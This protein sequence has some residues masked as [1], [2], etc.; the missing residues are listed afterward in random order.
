MNEPTSYGLLSRTQ[1]FSAAKALPL[2]PSITYCCVAI[3]IQHFKVFNSWFGKDRADSVLFRIAAA[4]KE[5]VDPQDAETASES[6]CGYF[7]NDSF[8]VFMPY[9]ETM[10]QNIFIS[11][12]EIVY[13]YSNTLGFMPALGV[14]LLSEDTVP[15]E[16]M[17]DKASIAV[18]DSKINYSDRISYFDSRAFLRRQEEYKLLIEFQKA[19]EN[20]DIQFYLQPQCRMD[21]GK[22]TGSEA[23]ARWF[24]HD[25]T[26]ILPGNFI[27][28][29]EKHGFIVDLD[30]YVWESVCKWIRSLLDRNIR[31]LPVSVNVSQIDI[32]NIDVASYLYGLTERYNVP[33]RF[34]RVE[35][36]E[37]AFASDFDSI[38]QLV[39]SLK[40]KGFSVFLDDFGSGYSSLNMLDKINTD[41]LKLDMAFLRKENALSKKGVSILESI[42]SMTKTLGIP[43]IIEGVETQEHVSFLQN[44]GCMYAQGFYF[45]RPMPVKDYENLL[46]DPQNTDYSGI[47]N[48]PTEIFHTREFMD[49]SSFP[50]AVLNNILGPVAF[51]LQDKE[52]QVH[53]TRFNRPFYDCI[54]DVKMEGRT[55]AIQNY[56]VPEDHALFFR[57]LENACK[58]EVKGGECTVRFYKSGGGA[59]WYHMHL[60][61]LRENEQGRIFYGKI[62]A[63]TKM[64]QQA[65]A[66]YSTLKQNAFSCMR[67]DL[68]ENLFYELNKDQSFDDPS[69]RSIN[70]NECLEKTAEL[71]IP[72]AK[73]KEAFKTFFSP[74]RLRAAHASGIYNEELSVPFRIGNGVIPCRFS[75]F[76]IQFLPD[77]NDNV[78]IFVYPENR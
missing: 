72:D 33:A 54:G 40:E 2:S 53:I 42:I 18:E 69:A 1:F 55:S 73:D 16:D 63:V 59:F 51:Y 8:C 43:V 17:Y 11:C 35:I 23:L 64:Y 4:I 78:Y 15:S 71:H 19:I 20:N 6:L 31:P 66:F 22:I 13:S 25:G 30:K 48:R 24:K 67:I 62:E 27:H 34:L 41:V 75:A 61:F 56:I 28:Y 46:T 57:M 52:G 50:D 39:A 7:G 38:R 60:F 45:Y 10:I 9:D 58:N 65:S 49:E 74:S 77:Q 47:K 29:L 44:L 12:K 37:S 36:T 5:A 70:V 14:Y 68:E 76:Y 32:K 3:D 26:M 21:T